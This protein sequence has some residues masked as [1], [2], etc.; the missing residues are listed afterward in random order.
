MRTHSQPQFISRYNSTNLP[1]SL[2]NS[3]STLLKCLLHQ[4]KL[5]SPSYISNNDSLYLYNVTKQNQNQL[6]MLIT[7]RS[8]ERK[9]VIG[10]GDGD[11]EVSHTER[12]VNFSN[13]KMKMV[14]IQPIIKFHDDNFDELSS[15]ING[16]KKMFSESSRNNNKVTNTSALTSTI[17]ATMINDFHDSDGSH[18]SKSIKHSP[19]S[20]SSIFEISGITSAFSNQPYYYNAPTIQQKVLKNNLKNV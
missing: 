12:L 18:Q 3:T 7:N 9:V 14:K 20:R 11:H 8:K 10:D 1:T 2:S 13:S 17:K 4:K 16:G 15:N 5:N 19:I 6:P